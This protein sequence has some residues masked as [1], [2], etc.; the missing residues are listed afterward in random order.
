MLRAIIFDV[1]HVLYD[2]DIAYL[3]E[4]LIVDPD[5]RAWFL[6]N[7]VTREWHFQ[8]DRGALFAD[9]SAAL[10]ARFPAHREFILAYG[11]RWLETIGDPVPGMLPLV[12]SLH[13]S[14]LP[15]YGITNFSGEFWERFRPTAPIFDLFADII[16]S[17]H[18]KLTKPNPA[19]YRLAID[20][21]GIDPA[22]T[23][24]VDDQPANVA[25]A[26]AAGMHAHRFVDQPALSAALTPRI[27]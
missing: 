9:T 4:K 25:A 2:W 11:E 12:R 15:I 10:I 19:I 26:K 7:V 18:E 3:Y 1:G 24:F 23:L 6:A 8:H 22:T 13:A 5:R 17:G 14:G 21:F 20:R 27:S 16:V